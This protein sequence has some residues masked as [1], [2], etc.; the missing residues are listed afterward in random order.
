MNPV[1][2]PEAPADISPFER[3]VWYADRLREAGV[4][5][6]PTAEPETI[7]ALYHA[8]YA[9][10]DWRPP[11]EPPQHPEKLQL[12]RAL[13][14]ATFIFNEPAEIPAAWGE[15]DRVLWSEGEG[16]LI[17]GPD[18]VGKTTLAQQLVLARIGADTRLLNQ[19]VKPAAGKVL[20]IAAD[21][22]RQAAR[23]FGRMVSRDI[24]ALLHDRL[25]VWRGPL[26]F[27]PCSEQRALA[28]L[29]ELLDC[30]DVFIDSLKDIA[31]DL[32]KDETGS[33]VN[34]AFQEVIARGIQLTALHHQRKEGRG[35]TAGGKPKKL[36]DVYG[37][38]WLTAGMGSVACI[39]GEPGDAHVDLTHLKQPAEEVGPLQLHHDHT[40]GRTRVESGTSTNEILH[41]YAETGLTTT[42]LA[43]RLFKTEKPTKN[44]IANAYRQLE[45]L[46]SEGIAIAVP[47]IAGGP[48]TYRPA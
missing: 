20:Y 31:L 27:D 38:R 39:W 2:L 47:S 16:L 8:I 44:Q 18:G 24:E 14:G 25:V 4:Q 23:S 19:P 15:R 33:R 13:D 6:D 10:D 42:R 7:E 34:L 22:P 37:S 45:S 26:P 40:R 5:F 35:D 9:D 11:R 29:A 28:D 41:E 12:E 36:A 3:H 30:T 1:T 46:V 32:S 43:E 48:T 17:V 21:R